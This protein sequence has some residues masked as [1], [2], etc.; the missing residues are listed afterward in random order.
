MSKERLEGSEAVVRS[1][2]QA[3]ERLK[4]D[5]RGEFMKENDGE[6]LVLW[7]S[8]DKVVSMNMVLMYAH[9][10]KLKAWW[11]DV[12]V[13]VWGSSGHLLVNDRE[14]QEKVKEMKDSGVRIIA[15]RRCAEIMGIVEKLEG[16][17]AEVF[18]TGQF[19]TDWLKSDKRLISV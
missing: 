11:K 3:P 13:L 17:G 5:E 2:S 16:L 12:T 19:L 4:R 14:V 9:N 7:T 6:L 15:C 18:Y 1:N 8:G 10:G